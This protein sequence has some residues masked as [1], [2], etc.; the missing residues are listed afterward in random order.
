MENQ[1]NR[2]IATTK[3]N[4]V[5]NFNKILPSPLFFV[6][7]RNGY[8]VDLASNHPTYLS[9][10]FSLERKLD[11]T[12]VCAIE[13]NYNHWWGLTQGRTCQLVGAVIGQKNY[14]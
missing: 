10:T 13:P 9:S 2:V 3:I 11:W 14:G 8:F 5:V 12:Q 4:G 6:T 7:K 1:M